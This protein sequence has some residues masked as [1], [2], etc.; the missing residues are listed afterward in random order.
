MTV[1]RT[2]LAG[3]V[4]AACFAGPVYA[5]GKSAKGPDT[6]PMQL[7]DAAKERERDNIDKQY[8]TTLQK[9]RGNEAARADDPWA[10]MRGDADVKSKAKR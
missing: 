6:T 5:Q 8:R 3:A 10:N 1:M 9:T 4:L 2:L 7:E